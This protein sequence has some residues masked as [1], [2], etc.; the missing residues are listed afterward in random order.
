[1][2]LFYRHHTK[3]GIEPVDEELLTTSEKINGNL[4]EVMDDE[5]NAGNDLDGRTEDDKTDK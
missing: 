5:K 3:E 1:M 4:N 2:L